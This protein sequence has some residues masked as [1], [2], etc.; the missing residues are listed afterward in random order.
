MERGRRNE[1]VAEGGREKGGRGIYRWWK[2]ERNRRSRRREDGGRRGRKGEKV[3]RDGKGK[4][5]RVGV[6]RKE[7]GVG[8]E[9]IDRERREWG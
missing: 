8:S 5:V 4:K 7:H 2:K 9:R 1:E 6:R 3:G